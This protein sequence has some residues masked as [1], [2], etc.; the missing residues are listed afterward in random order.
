MPGREGAVPRPG[1]FFFYRSVQMNK[2]IH[3][4]E[5][6]LAR[7]LTEWERRYREEPGRFQTETERLKSDSKTYGASASKYLLEILSE[8]GVSP[9]P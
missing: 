6:Q 2:K 8:Q 3:V 4:D 7:A 9:H 1:I 5:E